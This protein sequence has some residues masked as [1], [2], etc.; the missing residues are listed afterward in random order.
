MSSCRWDG[1]VLDGSLSGHWQ[2]RASPHLY[3]QGILSGSGRGVHLLSG[4]RWRGDAHSGINSILKSPRTFSFTSEGS[5]LGRRICTCRHCS[6]AST[7]DF[8]V[9]LSYQLT[10]DSYHHLYFRSYLLHIYLLCLLMWLFTC[11]IFTS[12]SDDS[13]VSLY[14][15]CMHM[16]IRCRICNVCMIV[17]PCP[18]GGPHSTCLPL[19]VLLLGCLS[20]SRVCQCQTSSVCLW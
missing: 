18:H 20:C 3:N 7:C 10:S 5:M 2:K 6:A 8:D 19:C 15:P 16:S 12:V 11:H 17:S 4:A 13:D 9:G 14:A 1:G